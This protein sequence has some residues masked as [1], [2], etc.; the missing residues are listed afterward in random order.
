MSRSVRGRRPGGHVDVGSVS[1]SVVESASKLAKQ[2]AKAV[3]ER[4]N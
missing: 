1:G 3:E 4:R 2:K